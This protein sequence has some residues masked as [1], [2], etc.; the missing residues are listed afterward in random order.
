MP[1]HYA[2]RVVSLYLA[3]RFPR[4]VIFRTSVRDRLV[5]SIRSHCNGCSSSDRFARSR[6]IAVTGD[7]M[8]SLAAA[9]SLASISCCPTVSLLVA[10]PRLEGSVHAWFPTFGF[11]WMYPST[12]PTWTS[13]AV[14]FFLA[15]ALSGRATS[16][17]AGTL[18]R[19]LG[20]AADR[21]RPP[22]R[23]TSLPR[24]FPVVSSPISRSWNSNARLPMQIAV[25]LPGIASIT[26]LA[27]LFERYR[28]REGDGHAKAIP[29]DAE[30]LKP[31]APL[32]HDH[33]RLD[34]TERVPRHRPGVSVDCF[35]RG[36][37]PPPGDG[38]PR[39]GSPAF[40]SRAL[41]SNSTAPA[42]CA[43]PE[44]IGPIVDAVPRPLRRLKL[45]CRQRSRDRSGSA[46]GQRNQVALSRVPYRREAAR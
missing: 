28:R 4:A 16:S 46:A 18:S 31:R 21:F 39:R 42:R 3:A 26:A 30:R 29:P 24:L 32:K 44:S 7:A 33:I 40:A 17:T 14:A 38:T 2:G 12:R 9:S 23:C 27:A 19:V 36:G 11:E 8:A 10:D 6:P 34:W 22:V 37:R 20:T 5:L 1:I 35:A 45:R 13:C 43:V 15:M 25:S 41:R